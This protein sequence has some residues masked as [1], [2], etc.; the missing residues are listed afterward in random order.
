MGD[1]RSFLTVDQKRRAGEVCL[2]LR[3]ELFRIRYKGGPAQS[4]GAMA[5][6][7]S[8]YQ[9][10]V[11]DLRNPHPVRRVQL[12]G[13]GEPLTSLRPCPPSIFCRCFPQGAPES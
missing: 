11:I 1:D 10:A 7:C 4:Y 6:N 2:R 3:H 13:P 12:H 5:R 8:G 9:V